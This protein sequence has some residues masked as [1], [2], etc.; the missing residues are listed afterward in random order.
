MAPEFYDGV[1]TFKSDIYSL[2]IIIIEI[3]TGHKGCPE[4]ERVRKA[5]PFHY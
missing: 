5:S 1:I 4:I 2:G 3:L